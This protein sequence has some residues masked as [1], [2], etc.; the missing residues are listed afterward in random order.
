MPC[1][2]ALGLLE[3]DENF[4]FRVDIEYCQKKKKMGG[5]AKS[6]SRTELYHQLQVSGNCSRVRPISRTDTD[7]NIS[8]SVSINQLQ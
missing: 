3:A 6:Y 5:G 4:P 8:V 2:G 7:T 1:V